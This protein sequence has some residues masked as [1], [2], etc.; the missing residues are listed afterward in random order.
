[1]KTGVADMLEMRRVQSRCGVPLGNDCRR[2]GRVRLTAKDII[3]RKGQDRSTT[4]LLGFALAV[5]LRSSDYGKEGLEA[6]QTPQ[7]GPGP[8]FAIAAS[9]RNI[10]GF[11]AVL[12]FQ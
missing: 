1:M 3:A 7:P 2:R 11:Q 12:E 9:E 6:G 5:P 4:R 8:S 10:R